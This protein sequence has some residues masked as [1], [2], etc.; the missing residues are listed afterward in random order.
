MR[1]WAGWLALA[2]LLATC[3]CNPPLRTKEAAL[4]EVTPARREAPFGEFNL[5]RRHG[6]GDWSQKP[7]ASEA[8]IIRQAASGTKGQP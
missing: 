2:V 1:T 3:G 7:A 4:Q 8:D 6:Q 5:Q